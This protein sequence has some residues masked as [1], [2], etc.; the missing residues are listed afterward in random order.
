M[1][2]RTEPRSPARS[3]GSEVRGAHHPM[4]SGPKRVSLG[5]AHRARAVSDNRGTEAR[6][7]FLPPESAW[8]WRVAKL[9]QT[10]GGE[11]CP[12]ASLEGLGRGRLKRL[13][14]LYP[15]DFYNPFS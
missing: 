1:R 5:E 15:L 13:R 4:A 9:A 6:R 10:K 2:R 11:G 14:I 3:R 12:A 8:H 7:K